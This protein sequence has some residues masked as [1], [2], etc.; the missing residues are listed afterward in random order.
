MSFRQ[1]IK[2][3]LLFSSL[4]NK[5]K[6]YNQE[7]DLQED[8]LINLTRSK[9]FFVHS[10]NL[11]TPH[12]KPKENNILVSPISLY[13]NNDKETLSLNHNLL[14]NRE[15]SSLSAPTSIDE[16]NERYSDDNNINDYDLT[17]NLYETIEDNKDNN[18]INEARKSLNS[19][20][21]ERKMFSN[22]YENI[23]LSYKNK[24]FINLFENNNN[25]KQY[26]RKSFFKKHIEKHYN[27]FEKTKKFR[28]TIANVNSKSHNYIMLE[29]LE[30]A[31][32]EKK[33]KFL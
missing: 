29:I 24:I 20:K 26:K 6:F 21:K 7:E 25:E 1:N 18:I 22:E 10:K 32:N 27:L 9:T 15:P 2:N 28:N 33:N 30:S 13:N 4:E 3:K 14:L 31:C 17:F 23:L 16:N 12:P 5:N 19:L 8:L 11:L